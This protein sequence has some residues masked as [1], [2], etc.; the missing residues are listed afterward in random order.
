MIRQ[1][2]ATEL[3]EWLADT[4]REQPLV[5]DVREPWEHEV[6]NIAGSRLL[7]MQD[8]PARVKELPADTDIVVL[9]HHGMRSLQVAQFLK[10]SGLERV[11]NLRG[12]IA[13]WAA[14]VDPD[15]SQY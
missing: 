2:Q 13:A 8:V 3:Q 7:P 15:M 9:C 1:L 11:F 5:L 4:T 14:Q 12:G 10:Q 6:C